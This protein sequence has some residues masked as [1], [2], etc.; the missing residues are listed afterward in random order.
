L[1]TKV[2]IIAVILVAVMLSGCK[3]IEGLQ[4]STTPKITT[5][6]STATQTPTTTITATT[7]K[8]TVTGGL[9]IV[10]EEMTTDESGKIVVKLDLL[11][12]S[13]VKI[14]LIKVTI[15]FLD[16]KG[17]L[18][19]TSIDSMANLLPRQTTDLIIP[20]FGTCK[21]VKSYEL[22]IVTQ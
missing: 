8:T 18:V 7:G 6:T 20:C 21:D 1:K 16:S 4:S 19:D 5:P 9:V 10:H 22:S 17:N 15:K 12:S 2:V 3:Y 14:N 13:D 11:N